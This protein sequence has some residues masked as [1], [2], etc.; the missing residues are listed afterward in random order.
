MAAPLTR[1]LYKQDSLTLYNI[2]LCNIADESDAFTYMKLYIKKDNER[3]DIKAFCS[4]YENIAMQEQYFSEAKRLIDT[5]QYRNKRAMTL[6]TFVIK[7]VKAV[8]ELENEVGTCTILTL[9]R[10]SGRGSAM[11]N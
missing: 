3:A 9:L 8:D 5:L 1:R 7:L 2:I 10:S 6:E 11:L 4:R